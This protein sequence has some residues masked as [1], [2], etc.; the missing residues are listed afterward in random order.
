MAKVAAATLLPGSGKSGEAFR[1]ADMST[2]LKL[3]GVDVGAIGDAHGDRSPSARTFRYLDGIKQEYRK[4]VVSGDGKKLL[5]AM[6]VGDNATYDT[7][8]QYYVNGLEL[9]EDPAS[10]ILPSSEGVPT[11]GADAL[12][13]SA[14]ICSCP[15]SYTHLTLPTICSV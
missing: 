7:L 15:V 12:P 9:P 10:L 1:G 11:L 5:G 13:D 4:L 3:L 8:M 14:S 2:K 6:L